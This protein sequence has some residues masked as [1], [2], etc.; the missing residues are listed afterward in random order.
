MAHNI[1]QSSI[2]KF[3]YVCKKTMVENFVRTARDYSDFGKKKKKRKFS[4]WKEKRGE[5]EKSEKEILYSTS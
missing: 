5:G 2:R 4:P 3:L 1:Y